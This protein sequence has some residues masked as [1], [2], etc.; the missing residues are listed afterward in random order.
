MSRPDL[1]QPLRDALAR[2]GKPSSDYDLNPETKLARNRT[3]REAA[4]LVPV[5]VQ[6]GV[7]NVILTKRSSALKHHPGQISFPG[8][9]REDSDK[10][11]EDAALREAWEEI[12]LDRNQVEVLGCLPPHETVTNFTVTPVLGLIRDDFHSKPDPSEV[13]EAFLVPLSH[14]MDPDRFQ[15]QSRRWMGQRRYYY[16]VPFGPY[17]IWGATARILRALADRMAP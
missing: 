5:M 2:A 1:V 17:Y 13:A 11:L 14:V 8:G 4:V 16:V 3:L 6:N 10:T 15:V 9:K 7:L 12:G